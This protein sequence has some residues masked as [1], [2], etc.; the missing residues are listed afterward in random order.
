M[1]DNFLKIVKKNTPKEEIFKDMFIAFFV[2]GFVG[3]CGQGIV[4]IFN[5]YLKLSLPDSFMMTMI[6]IVVISS[7]LTGL[8]FFDSMVSYCKGGLIV[9]TTGFAH[10]M[11]SSAMDYRKEGFVKGIGGNIFKLTGSIILYGI[12]FSFLF[13]LLRVVFK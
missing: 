8:G 10:A 9:P 6:V 2:G 3:A 1:V 11:T 7:L 5:N 4:F 12:V 13:A